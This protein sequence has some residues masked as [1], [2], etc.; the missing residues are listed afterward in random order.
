MCQFECPGAFFQVFRFSDRWDFF[1][2]PL[3]TPPVNV[4][5]RWTKG[6]FNY[7]AFWTEDTFVAQFEVAQDFIP[8][9]LP[10][11][12]RVNYSPYHTHRAC[13]SRA[14][15]SIGAQYLP[16]PAATIANVSLW[17]HNGL[18]QMREGF[19]PYSVRVNLTAKQNFKHWTAS[20]MVNDHTGRTDDVPFF[21]L[22]VGLLL[23][24]WLAVG[25]S[26]FILH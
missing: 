3:L 18:A 16:S 8:S 2:H 25:C 6:F 17:R 26:R 10:I 22:S 5:L 1:P 24:Q 4:R 15:A 23:V 12:L 19:V 21:R 11:G 13:Q 7:S 20:E 9:V 14:T